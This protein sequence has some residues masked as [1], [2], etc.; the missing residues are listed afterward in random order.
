MKPFRIAI[1][2]DRL[3]DLHRRLEHTRLPEL[4]G[5]GWER[6]VPVEVLREL[7]TRWRTG[8]D[9]RAHETALNRYPQFHTVIDGQPIHFVHVRSARPEALPLML[10][11]G[12]PDT[13]AGFL[14]A[15]DRLSDG[16]HLVVPS[17]PGFG[18][19]A[20][21]AGSGWRTRKMAETMTKLMANL[22]YA[23]YCVQGGDTGSHVAPEMGRLAPESVLGIHLN[24]L[25]TFPMGELDG[26]T[27]AEQARLA[28]ME[29]FN[30][31][32]LQIQSKSPHTLAY[33]LNDSPAAQLAW[34]AEM[35]HRLPEAPILDDRL[36]TIR[37]L[38]ELEHNVVRWTEYDKGGHFF[39][40]EQPDLF[41]ADVREFFKEL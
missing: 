40:M 20:P 14:D 9:W 2:Q 27:E 39:A 26:L 23:R 34:I 33:G 13:F 35:Y 11:H 5:A 41:A 22:G 28:A 38:A 36:L 21:L 17:L 3:D 6:G 31:G 12:W 37:R 19:S 30:D 24:A 18:F 1:G 29:S 16:F 25:I 7:L 8:Y 32:Y 4:P 15:V 10:L